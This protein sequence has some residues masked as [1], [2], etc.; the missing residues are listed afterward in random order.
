MN[1]KAKLS[2][3]I[4]ILLI[5]LFSVNLVIS[6]EGDFIDSFDISAQ[7]NGEVE[8]ITTNSTFIWIVGGTPVDEVY[9]YDMDGNF[10]DS[11]DISGQTIT[12]RGITT[13]STFI[14]VLG[15]TD[16][17]VYKYY[18]NGTFI[19]SFDI[20][21]ETLDPREITTNSTFIWIVDEDNDEVYKYDMDGNFIG[22]W[23]ISVQS[24]D[25]RGIDTD[26]E[27]IWVLDYIDDEV[28]K[29]DMDGNFIGSWDI[30]VQ[31]DNGWG[32]A[33]NTTFFWIVDPVNN[34]VYRYEGSDSINPDISIVFP[35]N[36]T[37]SSDNT[38][39]V[40]Y[41][42][43]DDKKLDSCWY[44]NDTY[45][46]NTTITCGT[47]ITTIM[48]ADGEHNLTIWVN[49]SIN[50]INSSII[51]FTIDTT[52]P[53]LTIDEPVQDQAFNSKDNIQFNFTVSDTTLN[54]DT[55]WFTNHTDG[56]NIT[57][58]CEGGNFNI[59]QAGSGT[60][61]AVLWAND[62]LNNV[63]KVNRTYVISLDAPAITLEYPS[64]GGFT[65][66]FSNGTNIYFNFTAIDTDG[67][68]T[69]KLWGNW[70]GIWHN[71]FTWINPE[72]NIQNFTIVNITEGIFKYN[73]ECN[74]T[75][76]SNSFALNNF[77]FGIDETFPIPTISDLD[78]TP[79]SQTFTFD[80][81][82]TDTNL[83]NCF[84]SV[85]NSTGQIDPATIENTSV[86]CNANDKSETIAT[87]TGT[88]DLTL[89]ANDSA[90]N[91]NSTTS[92]FIITQISPGNG[93][94]GGGGG[95]PPQVTKIPVIG[96]NATELSDLIKAVAFAEINN[97]CFQ[98]STGDPLAIAVFEGECQLTL[99]DL[100]IIRVNIGAKGFNVNEG[101]MLELFRAFQDSNLFQGFETEED[102]E[103]FGLFSSIL[104]ELEPFTIF[105][106]SISRPIFSGIF[107]FT[108]SNNITIL[109][110]FTS[111]RVIKSCNVLTMDPSEN[112]LTVNC[113]ILTDNTF[114]TEFVITDTGFFN[115]DFSA[116]ISLVSL[117]A[118]EF[119]EIRQL[120][121]AY[122]VFNF[123]QEFL[124]IQIWIILSGVIVIFI[125]L[126]ILAI[127]NK[128]FR[129]M[130]KRNKKNV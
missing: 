78:T 64:A 106:A 102:I 128:S 33:T 62:T 22:S 37:N 3:S 94:G 10:I 98:K 63:A 114:Q 2:L 115:K 104:G 88:F 47:N 52:A 56:E 1:K 4:I 15:G 35:S 27:F 28:Y 14:W 129:N 82:A 103:E 49:D 12:T 126:I 116:E 87:T 122:N 24:N 100:D 16:K 77:S 74:D 65:Q 97:F 50:N 25:P 43:N 66:W 6:A 20:G 113:S 79:G 71:N 120:N 95:G 48:W 107:S 18:M 96:I 41:T 112:N 68:D 55:C 46:T 17:E 127:S 31:S 111:N 9:K 69:C 67:L 19:S 80:T 34:E 26:D 38:L 39:D 92:E 45:S 7:F 124:G 75:L 84:Y 110:K 121:V 81:N 53:I 125:I 109:Q 119:T 32:I 42:V 130:V 76:G 90:G 29:Y 73:V 70:T 86:S 23:D 11:W 108:K 59:S 8:G 72:S 54:V 60:F 58:P 5:F 51:F 85:F 83:E 89:Y 118:P 117:D 21:V 36:N 13:N 57:I 44:S 105:P 61:Q 101:E 40:N 91:I 93:E 123:E 99:S 30:S